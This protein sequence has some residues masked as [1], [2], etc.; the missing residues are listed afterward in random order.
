M[1]RY[2]GNESGSRSFYIQIDGTTIATEN[3]VGKWNKNE[4]VNIEYPIPNNL[5][6]GKD[7]ITVKFQALNTNNIVG[8]LFYVRLLQPLSASNLTPVTETPKFK[9]YTKKNIINIENLKECSSITVYDSVG[10]LQ[11]TI[12][13]HTSSVSIKAKSGIY[14]LKIISDGVT[15]ISKAVV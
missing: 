3:V 2:W 13:T 12:H 14:L 5:T 1:V 7:T 8:G 11:Q 10:R 9:V 4:F 15:Q 6:E